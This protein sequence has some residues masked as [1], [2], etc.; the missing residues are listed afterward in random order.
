VSNHTLAGNANRKVAKTV[1]DLKKA[2]ASIDT[3]TT[4]EVKDLSRR[5][6]REKA[7]AQSDVRVPIVRARQAVELGTMRWV[8]M[9]SMALA[10]I[11]MAVIYRF[12][13][14]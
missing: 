11:A 2:V 9:I 7:A 5:A 1:H 8:L 3:P 4:N 12:V 10:V 14:G 6:M 13:A